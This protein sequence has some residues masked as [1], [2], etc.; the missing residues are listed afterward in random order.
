ME[1]N[2]GDERNAQTLLATGS[3][4]LSPC[5]LIFSPSTDSELLKVRTLS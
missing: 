3:L 5:I 4:V 1:G 2:E